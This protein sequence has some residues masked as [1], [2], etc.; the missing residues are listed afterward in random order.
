LAVA[1]KTRVGGADGPASERSMALTLRDAV[2]IFK[3]RISTTIALSAVVGA[4][5]SPGEALSAWQYAAL[6]VA[7]LA[8]SASAGAFNH[9]YERDLD[10]RMERTR[11]RPFAT[12]SQ[13][14]G[15]LW[16]I[17]IGVLFAAPGAAAYHL[18]NAAAAVYLLAG[19]LV[20][21]LVYTVWLKRRT[22]LNIVVGGL[23]GSFAILAGAAA[24]DPTLGPVPIALAI[25]LFLWTPPHFWSL[26]L[27]LRDD[28]ARAG[29]PMLPVVVSARSSARAIF[30][31]A[32]ALV[33]LSFAPLAYGMG[34]SYAVGAAVGGAYFL[35]RCVVLIGTPDRRNAMRAFFASLLQLVALFAGALL[36]VG[37]GSAALA[38]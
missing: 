28:Y 16:Y 27:A 11:T 24:V 7:V 19:A 32:A 37:L 10:R 4:A 13:H 21:G 30:G 38:G 6:A 17:C 2:S 35:H 18:F 15:A 33:M 20:Y 36:D 1:V 34:W 8:A 29:V 14:A 5:V 31:H 9:I 26:A 12:G 22:W 23:S 3:L 25:V